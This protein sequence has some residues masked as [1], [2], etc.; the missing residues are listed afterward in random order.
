MLFPSTLAQLLPV[1]VWLSSAAGS[2][3]AAS[4]LVDR[5]RAAVPRPTA[6]TWQRAGRP[7]RALLTL[8][9]APAY[10]RATVFALAALLSITVSVLAALLTG[11]APLAAADAAVAIVVSQLVHLLQLPRTVEPRP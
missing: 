9:Y 1:L 7:R 11:A 6:A 3:A 4:L 2:G 8:L 10:A 5:L